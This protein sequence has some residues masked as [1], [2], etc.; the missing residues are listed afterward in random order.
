MNV[1]N[2]KQ[3]IIDTLERN[4]SMFKNRKNF[5][6]AIMDWEED[7]EYVKYEL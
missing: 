1:Q 3:D 6:Y 2:I 4:I 7:L 5:E